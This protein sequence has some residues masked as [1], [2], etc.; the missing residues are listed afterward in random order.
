MAKRQFEPT[1]LTTYQELQDFKDMYSRDIKEIQNSLSDILAETRKTNGRVTKL[2]I[3]RESQANSTSFFTTQAWNV[4]MA[5]IAIFAA[6]A[7]WLQA[8]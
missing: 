6:A 2:E 1:I 5:I 7:A 4:I 8:W 3:Q